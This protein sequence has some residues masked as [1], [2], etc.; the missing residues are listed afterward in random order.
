MK[1]LSLLALLLTV[2]TLQAQVY[3]WVGE[4]GITVY[5]TT[6]PASGKAEQ[7]KPPPLP[8]EDPDTF[9]RRSEARRQAVDDFLEDQ[10][11]AQQQEAK[12]RAH[13]AL[14]A[15]NCRTA[16][17]NFEQ[18]NRGTHHLIRQPDG[19]VIAISREEG[20]R[21]LREAQRQ[22]DRYCN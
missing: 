4:D 12:E 8:S 14:Q 19:S 13:R 2:T 20:S 15:S 1:S 7:I 6:P 17:S 22:V 21:R 9:R 16:R 18:W 3:R 11:L 10:E 5:S